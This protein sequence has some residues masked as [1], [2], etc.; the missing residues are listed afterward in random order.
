MQG[1][2]ELTWNREGH[3]Y[4]FSWK[5]VVDMPLGTFFFYRQ[6]FT[7][8]MDALKDEANRIRNSR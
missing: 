7:Q 3:G 1:M 2:D 8:H 6:R 4:S 5:D